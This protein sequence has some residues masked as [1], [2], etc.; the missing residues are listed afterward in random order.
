[1]YNKNGSLGI[2][3]SLSFKQL[4]QGAPQG[5][6]FN[7]SLIYSEWS[8]RKYRSASATDNLFWKKKLENKLVKTNWEKFLE[9]KKGKCCTWS[10][11]VWRMFLCF[12]GTIKRKYW[13]FRPGVFCQTSGVSSVL[14]SKYGAKNENEQGKK[15]RREQLY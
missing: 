8:L 14:L 2:L 5:V 15:I 11:W 4:S 13:P 7:T 9:K 1:M 12:A 3:I 6:S 10:K